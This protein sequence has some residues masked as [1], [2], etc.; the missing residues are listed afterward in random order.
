MLST[1]GEALWEFI[2]GRLVGWLREN[3]LSPEPRE[4]ESPGRG[5][6]RLRW[7]SCRH[8]WF[9]TRSVRK[10]GRQSE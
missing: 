1:A 4:G 3:G 10:G 5:R 6:G 7:N 8:K 9:V 2:V